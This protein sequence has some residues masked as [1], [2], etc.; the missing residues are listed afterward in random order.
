MPAG[1]VA[2]AY[3]ERMSIGE[4]Q[5]AIL[6]LEAFSEGRCQRLGNLL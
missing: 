3:L 1:G 6:A 2:A 5:D 4:F